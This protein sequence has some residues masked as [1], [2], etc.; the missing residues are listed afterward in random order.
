MKK[1]ESL[2]NV[3]RGC[4]I[5][6]LKLALDRNDQGIVALTQKSIRKIKTKI[7]ILVRMSEKERFRR[8]DEKRS[9]WKDY[10]ESFVS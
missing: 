1:Y 7:D 9:Q 6:Q 4:T 5:R 3:Q 10:W 8:L 2:T